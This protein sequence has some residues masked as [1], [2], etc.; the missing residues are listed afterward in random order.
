MLLCYLYI[1]IEHYNSIL[2]GIAFELP[3]TL[4]T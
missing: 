4:S 2:V 1:N 3:S